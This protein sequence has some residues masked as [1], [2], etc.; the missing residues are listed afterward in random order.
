MMKQSLEEKIRSLVLKKVAEQKNKNEASKLAGISASTVTRWHTGERGS[1]ISMKIA[2]QTLNR[3]GVTMAE[4][5]RLLVEDEKDAEL[6]ADLIG[7]IE[8]DR[9]LV[10]AF[11][12]LKDLEPEKR[13]QAIDFLSLIAKN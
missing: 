4:L 11:S 9:Q 10:E 13:K 8:E 1:K 3:L 7:I 6:L 2:I 12:A 5:G